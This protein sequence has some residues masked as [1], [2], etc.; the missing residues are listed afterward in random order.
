MIHMELGLGEVLGKAIMKSSIS[1]SESVMAIYKW[2]WYS[3]RRYIQRE[4]CL[5]P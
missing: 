3:I 5:G 4:I 1:K 2:S